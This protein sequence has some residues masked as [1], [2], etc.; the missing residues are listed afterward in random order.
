MG[1]HRSLDPFYRT[2]VIFINIIL[3]YLKKHDHVFSEAQDSLEALGV[4]GGVYD[5]LKKGAITYL[6]INRLNLSANT[7]VNRSLVS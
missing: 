3:F 6:K 2:Q 7:V 4:Y 5:G 1:S